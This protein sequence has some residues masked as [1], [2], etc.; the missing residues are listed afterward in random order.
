MISFLIILA[1]FIAVILFDFLPVKRFIKNLFAY[2]KESFVILTDK[3]LTEKEKQKSLLQSALKIL[4][5]SCKIFLF[6]FILISPYVGLIYAGPAYS[7]GTNFYDALT[8]FKGLFISSI[9][10]LLYYLLKKQYGK[11]GL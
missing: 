2:Q 8:S 1:S 4:I 10:F 9:V 5:E 7:K 6:F 3:T 11:F